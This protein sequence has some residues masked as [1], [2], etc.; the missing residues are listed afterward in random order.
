MP[1]PSRAC[2][3]GT[4]ST[5][6]ITN[7]TIASNDG[8]TAS[9]NAGGLVAGANSSIS[10]RNTIVASNT[11]SSGATASNCS[12]G[13]LI[14]SLG[15]NLE[16][17]SDCGFK[18]TGD[19]ENTDPQFLSGGV[20]DT[21]GN[22]DTIALAANSPAVDAVAAN[23][24]GCSG[25]DQRDVARPQGPAC[26]IGAY[27]QFEPLEGEQFT[28]IIGSIE[29]AASSGAT[30]V[31][32]DGTSSSVGAVGIDGQ[33]TGTTLTGRPASTTASSTTSTAITPRARLRSTSRSVTL[34]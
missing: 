24:P 25:T 23:A 6:T 18:S 12:G 27:E 21:G 13:A 28:A 14:T 29:P 2:T 17:A 8:G 32:G 30:I 26:D 19:L 15:H 7:S 9:P 3:R 31:W 16:T 33:T 10:V 4:A 20:S 34:R 11:V 22:T 1:A 5:A